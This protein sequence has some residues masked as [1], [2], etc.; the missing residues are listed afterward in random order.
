M[1]QVAGAGLLAGS[2]YA[3]R[4]VASELNPADPG[5]RDPRAGTVAVWPDQ[6]S[7]LGHWHVLASP[8]AAER[9]GPPPNVCAAAASGTGKP[10]DRGILDAPSDASRS[11]GDDVGSGQED[12][13][14]PAPSQERGVH[15]DHW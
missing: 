11:S 5:P 8:L 13:K 12:C 7:G 4:W 3:V 1:S 10:A 6:E 15:E 9:S 2:E 14:G